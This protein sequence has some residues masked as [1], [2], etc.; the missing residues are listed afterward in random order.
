MCMHIFSLPAYL[1]KYNKKVYNKKT[2]GRKRSENIYQ[3]KN[4]TKKILDI[5]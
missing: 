1:K 3:N 2:N 5:N 4:E